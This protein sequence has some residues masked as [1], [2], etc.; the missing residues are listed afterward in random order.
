MADL[1]RLHALCS[2]H[3]ADRGLRVTAKSGAAV[4]RGTSEARERSRNL[5][6]S[7]QAELRQQ[8]GRDSANDELDGT[9]VRSREVRAL[10]SR[11]FGVALAQRDGRPAVMGR[12]SLL[13]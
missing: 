5:M 4:S 8:H 13:S 6:Q 9:S 2:N 11:G 7:A 12:A 3:A 10:A 1:G